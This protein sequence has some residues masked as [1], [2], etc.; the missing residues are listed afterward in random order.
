MVVAHQFMSR[1]KV[2]LKE[3]DAK[4]KAIIK[5]MKLLEG[6]PGMG[7]KDRLDRILY[8]IPDV[9]DEIKEIQEKK[10]Q[11]EG[12]TSDLYHT[13][14]KYYKRWDDTLKELDNK[15]DEALEIGMKRARQ[16]QEAC[17]EKD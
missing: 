2:V 4:L 7:E 5:V 13:A 1:F 12:V 3:N 9:A 11:E 15:A 16:Y 14:K 10:R 6:I 8:E 17:E